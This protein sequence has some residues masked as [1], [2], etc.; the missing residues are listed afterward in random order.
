MRIEFTKQARAEYLRI[1]PVF[2]EFAGT[3]S[4][5]KFIERVKERGEAL[6][7]QPYI[8]HP[9]PLLSNRHKSYRNISINKNYY[10]IYFV[11]DDIIWFTDIWDRRNNPA[12]LVARVK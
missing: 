10:I 1:V 4:A 11:E 5:N 12:S 9:E 3:R 2:A 6:L 7:K 8:G